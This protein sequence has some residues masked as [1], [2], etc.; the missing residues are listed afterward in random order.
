MSPGPEVLAVVALVP[1]VAGVGLLGWR[2]LRAGGDA[3]W[4]A[5]HVPAAPA[6]AAPDGRLRTLERIVTGHL[7]AREPNGMLAEQLRGLAERRLALRHGVRLDAEPER[8][9]ALLGPEIL[10]V[11]EA[12]P[13]RRLSLAQ[14]DDVLRR[15]EEV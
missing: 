6:D 14:V 8:A 9:A 2:A 10:A 5:R 11:L 12:R 7:E 1:A 3:G 4:A 15:I 13:P